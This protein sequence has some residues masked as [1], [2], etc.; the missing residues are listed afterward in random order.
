[1][2]FADLLNMPLPSKVYTE[3][4]DEFGDN[5]DTEDSDTSSNSMNFNPVDSKTTGSVQES[6]EDESEL[7]AADLEGFEDITSIKVGLEIISKN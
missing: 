1:M 4:S 3:N 7:D 5:L 2:S 6:D